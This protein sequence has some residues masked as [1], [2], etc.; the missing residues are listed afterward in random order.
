MTRSS[1]PR[2]G[3]SGGPASAV[4]VRAGQRVARD[5]R[6]GPEWIVEGFIAPGTITQF[7]GGS[8]AGKSTLLLSML[9]EVSR[10]GMFLGEACPKGLVL[11]VTEQGKKS[12]VTSLNRSLP[13]GT[14]AADL[15]DLLALTAEKLY[16]RSWAEVLTLVRTTSRLL[17][18]RVVVFDTLSEAADVGGDAENSAGASRMLYRSLRGLLH[19]DVALVAVRHTRKEERG[20]IAEA[21]LGSVA[22]SGA[23]DHLVRVRETKKKDSTVRHIDT[24]G[25]IGDAEDFLLD[26]T[27]TG[28]VRPAR[29]PSEAKREAR[30]AGLRELVMDVLQRRQVKPDFCAR[31]SW[32]ELGRGLL[33]LRSLY[34]R[35]EPLTGCSL[36]SPRKAPSLKRSPRGR[37]VRSCTALFPLPPLRGGERKKRKDEM[38]KWAKFLTYAAIFSRLEPA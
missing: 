23:A 1:S 24:K 14:T 11:Y 33:P 35:R 20:G 10:G 8:K 34:R 31:R 37:G 26:L 3:R 17:G 22:N 16:G 12:F 13:A 4:H 28:W 32:M 30:D 19:D 27:P 29:E 2:A 38:P 25:R 6:P 15:P 18:A 9:A 21:G 36:F 5:K 7:L